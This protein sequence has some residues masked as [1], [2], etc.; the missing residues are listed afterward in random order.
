MLTITPPMR[1][2]IID[3]HISYMLTRYFLQ[4][5]DTTERLV[6][7]NTKHKA[8][9]LSEVPRTKGY[10]LPSSMC[11]LLDCTIW[12]ASITAAGSDLSGEQTV[13]RS[14]SKQGCNPHL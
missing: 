10:S 12:T 2:L 1:L 8:R 5:S 4:L 13:L 14:V 11:C 9:S 7:F 3:V 6:S